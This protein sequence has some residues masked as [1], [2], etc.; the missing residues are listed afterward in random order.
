MAASFIIMSIYC[1]KNLRA[2]S[3]RAFMLTVHGPTG[4][5]RSAITVV[6][7][8]FPVKVLI[9]RTGDRAFNTRDPV[10]NAALA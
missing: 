8:P 9:E 5:M 6:H 4:R 2:R 10:W 3:D 7:C 1:G